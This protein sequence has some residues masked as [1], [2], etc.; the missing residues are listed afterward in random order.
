[1]L[2]GNFDEMKIV[3]CENIAQYAGIH[4]EVVNAIK[5]ADEKISDEILINNVLLNLLHIYA[6]RVSSIQELR[7]ISGNYLI[8][9]SLV[10]RLTTFALSNFDNFI[11]PT[12][13]FSFKSQLVLHMSKKKKV[14]YEESESESSKDDLVNLEALMTRRLPRGNGKYKGKLLVIYFSCNKDDHIVTRFLGRDEKDERKYSNFEGRRD[15]NSNK[16]KDK[17]SC[18]IAEEET[19]DFDSNDEVVYVAMKDYY[20]GD[21]KTTLISYV[22][23]SNRWIVDSGFSHFMT[24]DK[25]L[26]IQIIIKEGI[27]CLVMFHHVL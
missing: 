27:L 16:G 19:S 24:G 20:D 10:G 5:G 13:G 11:A 9:D 6:I 18:Y 15:G 8:Q 21:E 4:K 25:S 1:M 17:K 23:K 26:K 12:I 22:S 7:C 3:E 2:R 14:K